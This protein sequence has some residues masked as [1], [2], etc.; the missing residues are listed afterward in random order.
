MT[1]AEIVAINRLRQHEEPHE[2][3]ESANA[4]SVTSV[5][6]AGASPASGQSGGQNQTHSRFR[7]WGDLLLA[8]V[9]DADELNV[10]PAAAPD[11]QQQQREPQGEAGEQEQDRRAPALQKELKTVQVQSHHFQNLFVFATRPCCAGANCG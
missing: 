10:E 9:G 2:E 1:R 11:H 8:G 7:R 6:S 5:T 3:I 4:T